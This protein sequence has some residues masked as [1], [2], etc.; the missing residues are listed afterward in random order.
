MRFYMFNIDKDLK[1]ILDISI[2][3]TCEKNYNKLLE[4]ILKESMRTTNS[5]AGTLY[6]Y[7][8]NSLVF[9]I[10]RT[11]SLNIYKGGNG[12]NIDLPPV[13]FTEKNVCSY[14]AIHRKLINIQD[15][16]D[17][18]Q[19]DFSGPRN[20]D[21]ITKY[22]TK[23]MLVIPL[24]DH[25]NELIGVI[26]LINAL[27]VD[28]NIIPYNKR[29]EY[30]TIAL[31]SLAAVSLSNM[32]HMQSMKELFFSFAS[33]MASAIDERSPYNANHTQNVSYYISQFID[34]VNNQ[35]AQG[36]V[37][38][39][40]SENEKDQIILA[41]RL[42]DIGKIVIPLSVMDKADR[43]GNRLHEIRSRF[44][45]ISCYLKIDML[46]NRINNY[47]YNEEIDYLNN[48]LKLIETLNNS[49]FLSDDLEDLIN[50][51]SKKYY[52]K[53]DSSKIYY[54]TEEESQCLLIKKGTLT[55]KE[56]N[57]MES[58]AAITSKLLSNFKFNKQYENVAKWAGSHH[59]LLDGSG[60]PKGLTE[61]DIPSQVRIITIVDIYDA[62]TCKDRPYKKPMPEDKA[63]SILYSMADEG[64]L[65]KY[66]V[67]L[68]EKCIKSNNKGLSH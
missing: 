37:S 7:K 46:Q 3:L 13:P 35:Y 62:L 55:E 61:K 67:N 24:A 58:H 64:K 18:V 11:N 47:D 54:L 22:R 27:D 52:T 32:Q 12:E 9:K 28:N 8:D 38:E 25:E 5:D 50:I 45:L 26:Q 36:L 31:S 53:T 51:L 6:L 14:C 2:S 41:A 4:K 16:Y 56:R 68:F 49:S 10:M 65:D 42:H 33:V 17:N 40:F 1:N 34:F 21:S 19:F 48:S 39:F 30:T 20:Y 59:E 57:I 15:V 60:Y 44:E 66:Y 63:F 43:L 29:D 23:S